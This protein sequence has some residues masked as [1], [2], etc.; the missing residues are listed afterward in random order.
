MKRLGVGRRPL[1]EPHARIQVGA[2]GEYGLA[3]LDRPAGDPLAEGERLVGDHLVGVVAPGEDA[4]QLPR[5]LVGLVEREVVVRDQI[6]QRVGDA[7]EQGVERLL[8]ED[9]VED[10][11]ESAIRV[12]ER[13]RRRRAGLSRTCS[14]GRRPT[15]VGR[16][17]HGGSRFI[18]GSPAR[19]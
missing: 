8:G 12:D 15:G 2:V 17:S 6:A 13:E 4:P 3:V 1:D 5:H 7:L 11:R 10:V 19:A 16:R 18:G 14:D 9:V